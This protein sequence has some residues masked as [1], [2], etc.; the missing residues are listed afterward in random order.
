MNRE[1][2]ISHRQVF[3]F[4]VIEA[5][6]CE[7]SNI[8]ES[9]ES[10]DS[11]DLSLLLQ[12]KGVPWHTEHSKNND[13]AI[14]VISFSQIEYINFIA[15][16]FD[17][18]I[19]QSW[20]SHFRFEI[21][22][23]GQTWTSLLKE[24]NYRGDVKGFFTWH[25]PLIKTNFL[26]LIVFKHYEKNQEFFS[27]IKSISL[28]IHGVQE[29][30]A[31]SEL[32]RLWTKEN[33]IDTRPDY[34]WSTKINP[35]KEPENIELDLGS[36]NHVN[37]IHIKS[38]DAIHHYFPKAFYFEYSKDGL[39]WHTMHD[40]QNF[41]AQSNQWYL[42]TFLPTNMRFFR[43]VITE[44][45]KNEDGSFLSQI[46][47]IKIYGVGLNFDHS[48]PHEGITP[49][50]TTLNA[51]LIRLAKDGE[52]SKN[53]AVQA[54]DSRLHYATTHR[55]GIVRLA[56]NGHIS[57]QAVVQADDKRLRDATETYRGIVQLAKDGESRP[58]LAVQA[59]DKRLKEADENSSGILKLCPLGQS[60]SG[61][62]VQ[63]SDP[64]LRNGSESFAGIV[65]LAQNGED[66]ANVVVQGNDKR[67]KNATTEQ[68]GIL[69]FAKDGETA[70]FKAVQS[71]DKRLKD[72]TE[73][74][75][76]IVRLA[77]NGEKSA[78]AVVQS[79]DQRLE[80]ATEKQAGIVQ[81][82]EHGANQTGAVVQSDDPRLHDARA[83]KEHAHDYAPS[84]HSYADHSGNIWLQGY[85]STPLIETNPPEK[86]S[87]LIGAEL[88]DN[89]DSK[90]SSQQTNDHSIAI[91]GIAT[92]LKGQN[93]DIAVLGHSN[94]IGVRGQSLGTKNL[95]SGNKKSAGISGHGRD[96]PGGRFVSRND[97]A[98]I[99]GTEK[100]EDGNESSGKALLAQGSSCFQGQVQIIARPNNEQTIASYFDA[101]SH[102]PLAKGD[103]VRIHD[104]KPA[105]VIKCDKNYD[106]SVLGIVVDNPAL[107]LSEQENGSSQGVYVALYGMAEVKV[108]PS[109]GEIKPGDLLTTCKN[110][111]HAM[112]AKIEKFEQIGSIIGKALEGAKGKSKSIKI[113]LNRH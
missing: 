90:K 36:I 26:K 73:N 110:A 77:K 4:Q 93:Q 39:L 6:A 15:L 82:A 107:A 100:L 47:E 30:K 72:A 89:A 91:A 7:K 5:S 13:T 68:P 92:N 44:G 67:L 64:R 71:N 38:K 76:G 23:D 58:A 62:A 54:S 8:P 87:V 35:Q 33:I 32:D 96:C 59:N 16:E 19:P 34:G 60:L 111:G 97:Y 29:I 75:K 17:K 40:E 95:D 50:A 94:F 57:D 104:K 45:A 65:Q 21:S 112:K 18:S 27:I 14:A 101:D 74:Y 2:C 63:G 85:P 105:H 12:P 109:F 88:L 9:K 102:M 83:P 70:E 43:I 108:D 61:R 24:E 46:I 49:Y 41:E 86:Q 66:K 37:K 10:K 11:N 55:A 1:V 22:D 3:G 56:E 48:H 31:S 25:I 84:D 106:T 113:V 99:A 52:Y 103:I 51:G 81:L 69:T 42:W 78:L 20:P 80:N 98:L 28:G 53:I 79:N